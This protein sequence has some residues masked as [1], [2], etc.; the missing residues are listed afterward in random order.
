[1][2]TKRDYY[3]AL[4]VEKG[5]SQD[6]IKRAF[7]QKAKKLHPDQN[8]DDKNA[9]EKFKEI[10]EAYEVLSNAEKRQAYDQYGHA[11]VDPNFGAG[12][13]NGFGGFQWQTAGGS[14]FINDFINMFSGGGST[15]T[16]QRGPQAGKNV[17]IQLT[18]T[19]EEAAFGC[20]KDFSIRR[21][22]KCDTCHGS[23]AKPGTQRRTCPK[24][25][26]S[27]TEPVQGFFGMSYAT[28]SACH[29]AGSVIDEPCSACHGRGLVNR[30]RNIKN[31]EIPAGIEDGQ[32]IALNGQGSASQAGGPNGDLYVFVRV[33]AHKTF[34]REGF[35]LNCDLKISFGIAALGGEVDIPTLEGSM[36]YQIPAGTQPGDVIRIPGQGI[37]RLRRGDSLTRGDLKVRVQIDVPRKLNDRQRQL[38]IELEES[39]GRVG[40]SAEKQG[41]FEKV[42]DAFDPKN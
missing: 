25:K 15:R 12:G 42:R 20:K 22:E 34:H 2:A 30:T 1:M 7:R 18:I 35:D 6:E 28:C 37:V 36:K 8:P 38:L 24:C 31:V 3:E 40:K 16:R 33:K 21:D 9:E 10:N 14:D 29:G 11:G 26:G 5:A 4:G 32:G 41:F 19:L 23:G 17:Q 13:G 27:G 39:F